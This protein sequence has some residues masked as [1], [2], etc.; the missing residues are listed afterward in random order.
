MAIV[1]KSPPRQGPFERPL[2]AHALE[3]EMDAGLHCASLVLDG[4]MRRCCCSCP[5]ARSNTHIAVLAVVVAL[6]VVVALALVLTRSK[7]GEAK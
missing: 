6:D 3:S 1:P 2:W 4:L 5:S 7:T